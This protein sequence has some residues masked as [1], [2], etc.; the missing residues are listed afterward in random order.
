MINV[1]LYSAV[2]MRVPNAPN[3]PV[4]GEKPGFQ[5]LS[6]GLIVL[7]CAEVVKAVTWQTSA[8]SVDDSRGRAQ[9]ACLLIALLILVVL[10]LEGWPGWVTLAAACIPRSFIG[11]PTCT[12]RPDLQNTLRQSYDNTK[13]TIFLRR[14]SNLENVLRRTQGFS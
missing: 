3:T 9:R 5:S 4:S 8:F 2:I 13:V 10:T 7:L 14:T 6:K 1:D 11:S 12:R